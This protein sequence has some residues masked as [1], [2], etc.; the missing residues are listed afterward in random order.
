MITFDI[1]DLYG[2]MPIHEILNILKI[3][4]LENN[5]TQITHKILSLLEV[6]L[7]QNYFTYHN[8]TYQPEKAISMGSPISSLIAEIFLTVLRRHKHK[9]IT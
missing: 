9:T 3:K 7:S 4:V 1:K 2:L 6:I 5:N 8:K